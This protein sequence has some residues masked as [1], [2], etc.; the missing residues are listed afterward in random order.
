M[1]DLSPPAPSDLTAMRAYHAGF[2]EGYRQALAPAGEPDLKRKVLAAGTFAT[3]VAGAV[4]ILMYGNP[5]TREI[6]VAF[7]ITGALLVATTGAV[8]VLLGAPT[9]KLGLR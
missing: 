4:G 7:G 3:G 1:A 6:A 9:P 2:E 5:K 8:A